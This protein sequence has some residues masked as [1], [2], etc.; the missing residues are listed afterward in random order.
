MQVSLLNYI[1]DINNT[2]PVFNG[3]SVTIQK[4]VSVF[5]N[6]KYCTKPK[7]NILRKA[8]IKKNH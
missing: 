3:Y 4:T 1:P 7:N 2:F 6:N 8:A 5:Y